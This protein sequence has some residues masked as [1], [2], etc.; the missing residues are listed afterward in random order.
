MY[1]AYARSTALH[2]R[3][4]AVCLALSSHDLPYFI[5]NMTGDYAIAGSQPLTL[6]L[7]T[8]IQKVMA[9]ARQTARTVFTAPVLR[10]RGTIH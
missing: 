10:I 2:I 5:P 7:L 9:Y 8:E 4:R 1:P 3:F 6:K